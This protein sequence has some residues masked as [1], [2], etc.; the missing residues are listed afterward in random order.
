MMRR[1]WLVVTAVAVPAM[2]VA[3]LPAG[4]VAAARV[5]GAGRSGPGLTVSAWSRA[6]VI[7]GQAID[8]G[9]EDQVASLSCGSPG[10]CAGA[11]FYTTADDHRQALLVTEINGSWQD[12][13]RV[14]GLWA[15]E[16]H[17]LSSALLQVSCAAAGYCTAVGSYGDTADRPQALVVTERDGSWGRAEEVHT[18]SQGGVLYSVSCWAVGDC[19]AAGALLGSTGRWQAFVVGSSKGG[20]WGPAEVVPGSASLNRGGVASVNYVSCP[21]AGQCSAAGVYLDASGHER[22]FVDS[23]QD[24]VWGTAEEMPGTAAHNKTGFISVYAL[25]CGSPGNC[26]AGGYYETSEPSLAVPYVED[27][28]NGTWQAVEPV[29]GV[30]VAKIWEGGMVISLSCPAAGS[31]VAGGQFA[32]FDRDQQ[33]MVASQD[34]G[35]WG[36]GQAVPGSAALNQGR[37]AI[38]YAVSCASP[39]NCAAGGVYS[40][41]NDHTGAFIASEGNGTWD[42]AE[43]VPGTYLGHEPEIDAIACPAAGACTAVGSEEGAANGADVFVT[44]QTLPS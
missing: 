34:G 28:V 11:G 15:L 10:N 38:T 43:Q 41:S 17:N 9:G 2:W 30:P 6:K 14:R 23:E 25:S 42:K 33:A 7:P 16:D 1:R 36:D 24:Y 26:T 44:R 21:A 20:R 8:A 32:N 12:A 31:C 40:A 19:T 35:S 3:L 27:Q 18:T 5:A 39:G 13:A 22:A 4:G 29:P 37:A